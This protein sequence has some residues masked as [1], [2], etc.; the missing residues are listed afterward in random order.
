MSTFLLPE[1]TRY[2]GDV[3]QSSGGPQEMKYIILILMTIHA[4]KVIMTQIENYEKTDTWS[5]DHI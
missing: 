2:A 4:A 1:D 3:G 5:D